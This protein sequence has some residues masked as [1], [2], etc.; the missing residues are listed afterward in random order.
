VRVGDANRFF[1][2]DGGRGQGNGCLLLGFG[3]GGS[4]Q[5]PLNGLGRLRDAETAVNQGLGASAANG[6]PS[7]PNTG[8][9]ASSGGVVL[10]S[11]LTGPCATSHSPKRTPPQAE[12]P[13][14]MTS[15]AK[16]RRQDIRIL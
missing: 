2:G 3:H 13:R 8:T 7:A 12:A 1:H 11:G 10:I 4:R 15:M 14:A 16:M 5:F 6:L 9:S